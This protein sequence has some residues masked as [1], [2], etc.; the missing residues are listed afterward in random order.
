MKVSRYCSCGGAMQGTITP[1]AKAKQLLDIWDSIHS[2][3]GHRVVDSVTASK[4][5]RKEENVGINIDNYA[6]AEKVERE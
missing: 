2:G 3:I 5:R 4:A 1:D 6:D